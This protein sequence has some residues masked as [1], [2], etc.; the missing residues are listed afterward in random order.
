MKKDSLSINLFI[1]LKREVL[2]NLTLRDN[3]VKY[4]FACITMVF[5]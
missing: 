1:Q 2:C 3:F 4:K 5:T